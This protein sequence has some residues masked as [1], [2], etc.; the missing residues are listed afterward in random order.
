MGIPAANRVGGYSNEVGPHSPHLQRRLLD[1]PIG[2]WV[3]EFITK[4]RRHPIPEVHLDIYDELAWGTEDVVLVLPRSFSK[5][6][7]ASEN[8][9]LFFAC[10]Y[11]RL[12]ELWD[13]AT[14]EERR[15]RRLVYPFRRVMA[16]SATGPKAEEI[17]Y[18]VRNELETNELILAEYGN[19]QGDKWTERHLRTRDG[20]EFRVA[21]RGGQIRGF[22]PE[23]LILDDIEDDEEVQSDDQMLKTRRWI[24]SAVFNTLDETECR[25]LFIGT[26]LHPE[27]AL[28]YVAAKPGV[29]TIEYQAYR[30]GV[31]A[32]GHE[33]WPSKWPHARLMARRAKIGHRAFMA[34]FMNRPLITE[35]P[36]FRLE[37]FR[38][39]SASSAAFRREAGL[40]FYTV[41]TCDPAISR[42]DGA[43]YSAIVT[44][45]ANFE[46]PPKV[47]IRVGGVRRGHWPMGTTVEQIFQVYDRFT[48]NEVG[49]ECV[50][51]QQ[52]L[53]DEVRI[54][55]EQMGRQIRVVEL[56]P[57]TDKERRANRVAPMVERGQVFFDPEDAEAEALIHECVNFQP[58]K[59][60]VKKDLMDAFVY[61]LT[62]IAEWNVLRQTATA[63]ARQVLPKGYA[64]KRI[65]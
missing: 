18:H 65:H 54:Y 35:N 58:G 15:A 42:A 51:Y 49:I 50:A 11:P 33:L 31:M 46:N 27:A 1:N 22:R 23:L 34:E 2:R 38:T 14:P 26:I 37:W 4:H 45:S 7:V 29:R 28:R 30:D 16:L 9:P 24:D 62:M 59:K 41:V 43:D 52:A 48:A 56:V 8:A 12:R 19:L 39:Y 5:T 64:R 21:G 53:I 63:G 10:E 32:A 60:N 13:S 3:A 6:T 36:I 47:Y 25:G 40:G 44:L 57:D 20:F 55:T 17:H 61:G